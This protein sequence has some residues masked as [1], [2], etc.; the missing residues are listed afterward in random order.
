QIFV[1]GI[2]G[3]SK[4]PVL[5][6]N[7]LHNVPEKIVLSWGGLNEKSADPETWFFK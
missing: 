1:I 7:N 4:N 3:L 6:N 5:V 2:V